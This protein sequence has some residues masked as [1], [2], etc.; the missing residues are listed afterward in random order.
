MSLPWSEQQREW[1]QAMGH[2]V[3]VLALQPEVSAEAP[4]QLAEATAEPG[5]PRSPPGGRAAPVDRLHE[6]LLR[7]T[8]RRGTDAGQVLQQ[9]SVDAEVLRG[10]AGAKRAAWRRLREMRG[11]RPR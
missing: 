6:A 7:A 10:D 9:L 4:A 11:P 1:L 5:P 2:P 8:G 3:L